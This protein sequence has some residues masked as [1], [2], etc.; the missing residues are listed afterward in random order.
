MAVDYRRPALLCQTSVVDKLSMLIV[1][2][3][4]IASTSHVHSQSMIAQRFKR[5]YNSLHL[6]SLFV[7]FKYISWYSGITTEVRI[8]SNN[9]PV[10]AINLQKN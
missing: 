3:L 8:I 2:V 5:A 6:G 1:S 7:N 4:F 9:H 10:A